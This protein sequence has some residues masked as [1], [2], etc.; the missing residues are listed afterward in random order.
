LPRQFEFHPSY[1]LAGLL[2]VAHAAAVA[3]LPVLALPAWAVSMLMTL[4]LFSLLYFLRRDAWLRLPSSCIG[5]A[6]QDAG[7]ILLIRR[8]GARVPCQILHD[9]LVTP[10]LTVLNVLPKGSRVARGLVILPDSMEAEPFR[11]LRV[12]LRR[13]DQ[14]A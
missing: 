3:I 10:S 9:S 2:I 5:L 8:D 1:R 6:Q 13:G 11:R 4:L 12:W 7:S 14:A